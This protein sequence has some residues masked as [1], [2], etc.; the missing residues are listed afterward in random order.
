MEPPGI[1]R[2]RRPFLAPLWVSLL[3]VLAIGSVMLAVHH[4]ATT[5]LVFLVRPAERDPG[6]ISDPPVSP[7]GEERARRLA[8]MFGEAGGVARI[9]AIYESDDRRALQTGAPL[10]ERLHRAPV[11][12]SA[13][14]A[15]AAARRALREH[16][17]GTLLMIASS[18]AREQLAQEFMSADLTA[19][20]DGPDFICVVSIPSFG[21]AHRACFRF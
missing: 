16:P 20:Q 5:T 18:P 12:F 8:H 19:E 17:G 15:R 13:A 1:T 21:R 7:E 2:H 14:A 9:D 11:V 6:T 4:A 10:V 3:A